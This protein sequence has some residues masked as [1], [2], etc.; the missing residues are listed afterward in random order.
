MRFYDFPDAYDLFFSSQFQQ[1]CINFYK[2]LLGIKKYKDFMDVAVGTGQMLMPLAKM[3]YSVAGMDINPAMIKRAGLNFAKQKIIANLSVGDFRKI[4]ERIKRQFDCVLCTGNSLGHVRNDEIEGVIRGMD[5]ILLPGGMIYV[6]SKNWE[7]MQKR[8]Q[9]FYLFNPIIRERGRINYIQVW[10][11]HRDGSILFN[12]L[13]FEEIENKII[14]KRQFYERYYPFSKDLIINTLK[15]LK[16]NNINLCKIGEAS[17]K[18]IDKIEWYA[19]TAEKP[20]K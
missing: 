18:D 14:S 17:M 1:D 19:I 16:Y 4:P 8:M 15:D 11:W 7:N 6:D 13:I 12:Y 3:G 10:D 5:S 9:R 20:I 2:E